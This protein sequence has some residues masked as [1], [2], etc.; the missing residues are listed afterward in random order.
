MRPLFQN[1][2]ERCHNLHP[3]IS[4]FARSGSAGRAG[5]RAGAL[6]LDAVPAGRSLVNIWTGE[7]HHGGEARYR[8]CAPIGK[9][10]VFYRAKSEWA[11]L[12]LLYG[13]LFMARPQGNLRADGENNESDLLLIRQRYACRLKKNSLWHMRSGFQYSAGY[14]HTLF[15]EILHRCPRSSGNLW[16][17]IFLIAKFLPH[18]PIWAIRYC[19]RLAAKNRPKGKFRP[20]AAVWLIFPSSTAGYSQLY[21]NT[22]RNYGQ[23]GRRTLLFMLYGIMP[24]PRTALMARCMPAITKNPK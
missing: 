19:A 15:V 13:I 21:R 6:R 3:E 22:V 4:I 9:P 17:I 16:W 5:S 12:L 23:N 10:P 20:F 18:L 1:L 11:S 14:W 24:F 8:G 7:A 2:R